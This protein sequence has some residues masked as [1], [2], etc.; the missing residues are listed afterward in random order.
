[1]Q[2]FNFA[3]VVLGA[4]GGWQRSGRETIYAFVPFCICTIHNMD[5]GCHEKKPRVGVFMSSL[6]QQT[7]VWNMLLSV[8][9][10][11]RSTVYFNDV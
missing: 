9:L 11:P 2:E 1:M 8:L 4:G 6:N 3:P 5:E 10:F 7:S